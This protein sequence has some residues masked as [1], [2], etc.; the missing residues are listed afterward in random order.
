MSAPH[1]PSLQ[2]TYSHKTLQDLRALQERGALNLEPGFQ[3]KSVWGPSDR[4]KLIQSVLQGY[5]IPSIFLYQRFEDNRPVYDV[6][7]GK[8]RLEALFM[9]TRAKGFAR[10]GFAVSFQFPEDEEAFPFDWKDLEKWEKAGPVLGYKIQTVEIEGN[11]ADIIDL[12]VRI[13][14]TGKALSTAEKR[15]AR[16]YR[17]PLLTTAARL[18]RRHQPWLKQQGIL[19][20]RH[21]ARQKDIEVTTELLVSLLHGGL[22]HKKAAVDKAVAGSGVDGRSLLK[23][24][25]EFNG[26]M[27]SLKKLFPELGSTRLTRISEFYTLF[28]VVA[29]LRKGGAVLTDVKRRRAAQELIKRFS[30]KVDEVRDLQR[31]AKGAKAGHS[32]YVDY[33]LSV[34]Q[35]TDDLSRRKR[36]ADII[37]GLLGG[38]FE[39]KDTRRLFTAEQRRLLWNGEQ[40]PACCQCGVALSWTNFQVDHVK[41]HS[42]GGKTAVA[43]AELICQPCNAKKGAR[44][45]GTGRARARS[46][47]R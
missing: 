2:F 7:D 13:N 18:A 5:P 25:K 31:Q 36:R 8:Q 38:L 26:T 43:N 22:I 45:P 12:F 33:L 46:A 35:A 4:K 39:R 11:L 1:E 21:S 14:S 44:R 42:R 41:A 9:Y 17:N 23:A 37:H 19:S 20:E 15:K 10:Q 29:D 27:E 40:R 47:S 32:L 30:N 6:I 34:Q 16:F 3:R 24:E 28:M